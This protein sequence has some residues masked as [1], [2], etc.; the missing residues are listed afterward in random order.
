M[1]LVNLVEW[2]DWLGSTD[3]SWGGVRAIST[4]AKETNATAVILKGRTKES[5]FPLGLMSILM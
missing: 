5:C 4:A 3:V 1:S 2:N